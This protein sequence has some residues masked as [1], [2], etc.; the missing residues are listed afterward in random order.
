MIG[1]RIVEEQTAAFLDMH[2]CCQAYG[3][4][5]RTKGHH[6]LTFQTICMS[7]TARGCAVI[8]GNLAQRKTVNTADFD[9]RRSCRTSRQSP[10]SWSSIRARALHITVLVDV[11]PACRAH[12]LLPVKR[13]G[14]PFDRGQ[15]L[16]FPRRP[17]TLS[18]VGARE[19][20]ERRCEYPADRLTRR[21]ERLR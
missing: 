5:L 1:R 19:L 4:S 17:Y 13:D 15:Y 6:T 8:V 10:R 3:T 9:R 14:N 7:I 18:G 11:F 20:D 21:I 16:L 12:D 2:M